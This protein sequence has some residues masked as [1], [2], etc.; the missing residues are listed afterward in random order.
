VST[1]QLLLSEVK[2][3]LDKNMLDN[4]MFAP[5]YEFFPLKKT[6]L[7]VVKILEAQAAL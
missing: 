5:I 3:V 1:A 7:E 2:L 4:N 6:I